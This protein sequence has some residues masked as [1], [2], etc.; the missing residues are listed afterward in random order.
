MSELY[1]LCVLFLFFSEYGERESLHQSMS[2]RM[3]SHHDE[4]LPL[5]PLTRH[6]GRGK[7]RPRGAAGGR[8]QRELQNE[9]SVD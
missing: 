6:S 9:E 5:E 3:E 4:A 8:R 7:G 1:V 2:L